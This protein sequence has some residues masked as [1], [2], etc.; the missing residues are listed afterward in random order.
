MDN[1]TWVIDL[2]KASTPAI[3]ATFSVL[4]VPLFT[5]LK[6]KN[7]KDFKLKTTDKKLSFTA[8]KMEYDRLVSKTEKAEHEDKD[9]YKGLGE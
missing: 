6:D 1:Q 4:I 5:Y 3:I 2:I 8:K 9:N 7:E